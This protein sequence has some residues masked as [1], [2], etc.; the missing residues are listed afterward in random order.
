MAGKVILDQLN[1]MERSG[2]IAVLCDIFEHAAWVADTAFESRPFPTIAALHAAMMQAVTGS[3]PEKQLAFISAH[4][5]L[6]SKVGQAGTMTDA[7]KAEQGALGL[8]RLSEE[9]FRRF[10][11]LNAAYREKFG[12]P[13]V[14][15]VA[16]HTRDSILKH[17]ARRL[18]NPL[19]AERSAALNEIGL[20]TR[21]RLVAKVEGPGA[22]KTDGRLSAH[23]LDNVLGKPA[24]GVRILLSEIGQSA[25]GLLAESVT[26]EDGRTDAPLLSGAPLRIGTY[27]LRFFV[28]GYFKAMGIAAADPPYLDEVPVRFSIAEPEGDYHVPLLISPYGYSTYRGS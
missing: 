19:E 4:P 21:L 10:Q 12:F 27:E 8:N 18:S 24:A 6:G 16:R 23:V 2:F 22:P 1:A 25:K 11:E 20:I 14:I 15:C 7:S 28:A 9:E 3:P 13:F 5:E 26:N 17:F